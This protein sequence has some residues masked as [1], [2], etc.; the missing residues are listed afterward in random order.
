MVPYLGKHEKVMHH[1]ALLKLWERLGVKI[2]EIHSL[3]TFK[4]TP[5]MSEFMRQGAARRASSEHE[6]ERDVIKLCMNAQYGKMLQDASKNRNIKPYLNEGLFR[7]KAAKYGVQDWDVIR[8]DED[9]GEFLG[10]IDTV[11]SG[12]AVLKTPRATGFAILELTKVHMMK[13]HYDYYKTTY[14]DK[15]TLHFTD[16]D[17]LIYKIQTENP[18]L[19]MINAPDWIAFDIIAAL[20]PQALAELTGGDEE[21][22]K[23]FKQSTRNHERSSH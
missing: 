21:K 15:A 12:G 11:K 3:W 2:T 9:K 22:S 6:P 4:Q 10:L 1:I 17:S 20:S 23:S 18:L 8:M 7:L 19:D 13:V 5:W 16:T 14:A